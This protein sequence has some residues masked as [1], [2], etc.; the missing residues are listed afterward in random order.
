VTG[1]SSLDSGHNKASDNLSFADGRG[2]GC[3]AESRRKKEVRTL[4]KGICDD[5]CVDGPLFH[6][7]LNGVWRGS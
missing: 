2:R 3:V 6:M 5:T 7:T 4:V 1:F